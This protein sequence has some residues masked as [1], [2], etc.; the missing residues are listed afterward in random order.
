MKILHIVNVYAP[1]GGIETYVIDL[2]SHLEAEGHENVL[3]YRREHPRTLPANGKPVYHVPVTNEGGQDRK[4][5]TN[6]IKDE[7][8]TVIYVHD[9]YDPILIKQVAQLAPAIGYV[10]IFYPVCPGLGKLY[11]RTD[12]V[13]T[14]PYGLG[15]IPMIY[16]QRC[17]SARHPMNV[18]NIMHS[19]K[20]YLEAYHSLPYVIVASEYMKDLMIQNGIEAERVEI[21]PYFIPIPPESEVS[22]PDATCQDVMFAGRLDYEKGVPYLLEALRLIP[23]PHQLLIAGDGSLSQEYRQLAENMG[24][25]DRV[26][27]LGWLSNDELKAAYQRCAVTVMPTIMPEPFGKVGVEAMANGRPVVAFDVGGIS[28]WL[29]DGYNGFLVPARDVKQLAAKINQLLTDIDL[30][31]KLG[32]NGRKYVE[33]NYSTKQHLDGLLNILHS[34][35]N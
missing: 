31:A 27:F 18:Y 26:K 13:C 11:R 15:C 21:L 29:K 7:N 6:I 24:V 10:H 8:P 19:T 16:L 20:Q 9:A 3:I 34:I 14:R 35:A 23:P 1:A 33:Q 28:D 30:A 4:N 25:A 12:Q 5:I 2:I 22:P 32:S 17:A